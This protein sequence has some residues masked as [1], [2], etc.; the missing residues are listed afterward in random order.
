MASL[1][2]AV[3][4]FFYIGRL[5]FGGTFASFAA[6]LIFFLLNYL[7]GYKY[8]LYASVILALFFS[9]LCILLGKWSESYYNEKDSKKVVIDELAGY[10]VS[11]ILI[12]NYKSYITT[13]LAAFAIFRLFDISKIF[14]IKKLESFK[15]GYGIL[16]DDI[17]ASIYTSIVLY[18]MIYIGIL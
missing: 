17:M 13:G 15:S 14:P 10:F 6:M 7:F 2:E 4:T 16:F 12:F 9:F 1:K 8:T 18:I 5:P 3:V 11:V